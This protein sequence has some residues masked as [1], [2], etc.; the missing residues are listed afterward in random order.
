MHH[1]LKVVGAALRRDP[2]VVLSFNPGITEALA[3]SEA[4]NNPL[5][6]FP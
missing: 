4:N 6:Q 3:D 2:V 5:L 1:N